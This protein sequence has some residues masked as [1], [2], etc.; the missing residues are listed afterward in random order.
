MA[1]RSS[2]AADARRLASPPP[3]DAATLG[4]GFGAVTT[5]ELVWPG[6]DAGSRVDRSVFGYT[7]H[8]PARIASASLELTATTAA[9]CEEAALAVYDLNKSPAAEDLEAVGASLVRS[10][11][12]A[13][14]RIEN[15]RVSHRRVA[16]A[17]EHPAYARGAALEVAGNVEAMRTALNLADPAGPFTIG[18]LQQVHRALL[19][20]TRDHRWGGQIRSVQNWVG[21]PS[22]YSP[23]RAVYVPP[24]PGLVKPLLGDLA[25]FVNRADLPVVAHAAIA[26][27]QFEAI[28]PFPDGNGRTGRCLVHIVFERRQLTPN[29]TPPVS[30][31]L[32][33][34]RDS[35]FAGLA[36]Y[37]QH[38]E[39][40]EWVAQFARA[41]T[42]AARRASQLGHDIVDVKQRWRH[43]ANNPRRGSIAARLI[44]A[45]PAAP[46][47]DANTVARHLNVDPNVARRGITALADAGVVR[48]ASRGLRN[49]VWAADDIFDLLDE[50]E[51]ALTDGHGPTRHLRTR[52]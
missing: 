35:Y 47:L 30:A 52:S 22:A 14:S 38:G 2:V 23:R 41:T 29:V 27:A 21:G 34:D 39:V 37:Q 19:A 7:A 45:L 31:A 36:G 50:F 44:D 13:S 26:H 46:I 16:E 32:M 18:D 51:H 33:V 8:L 5:T 10:E 20:H 28:H 49:R 48:Q 25:R 24:P 3:A 1:A 6:S 12:V 4:V 42:V 43:A 40:D 9:A 17:L 11:S 15:L